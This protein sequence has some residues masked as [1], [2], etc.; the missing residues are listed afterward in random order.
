MI[1]AKEITLV[2]VSEIVL[3]P[4][5]LNSHGQDQVEQLAKII[6]STGFRRPCTISN[7]SGL[8]VCGEGRY[9][10]A[11]RLG[12]KE[13]PCMYQDY[14][15]EEQEFADGVADN[16][17][18]KQS[19]FDMS[20][21]HVQ[22]QDLEPFDLDLLGIIDF[23]LEPDPVSDKKEKMSDLFGAPPFSVIDTRQGYWQERKN[24]WLD[25][26]IESELGRG[27]GAIPRWHRHS[28]AKNNWGNTEQPKKPKRFLCKKNKQ[29]LVFLTPHYAR[30]CII[31]FVLKMEVFWILLPA[32]LCAEW[33]QQS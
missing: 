5:N 1:K 14:D 27:G 22:L 11:L 9:L 18:D 6:K 3:N 23:K 33:L 19:L 29:E 10:A 24:K 30:P 12:M 26:G 15:S 4:K 28:K 2:P 31:G 20:E 16:M 7:R 17:I 13:I 25:M 32:G 8:L 21:L